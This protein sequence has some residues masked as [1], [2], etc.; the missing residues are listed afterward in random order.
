[1]QRLTAGFAEF[2]TVD[3]L[4]G[5]LAAPPGTDEAA[6]ERTECVSAM[7]GPNGGAYGRW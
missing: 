6:H 3:R 4:R 7:Q 5:V 2:V 1:V